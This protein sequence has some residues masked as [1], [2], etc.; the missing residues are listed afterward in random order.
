[1]RKVPL[2]IMS[3]LCISSCK[4]LEDRVDFSEQGLKTAAKALTSSINP[5]ERKANDFKKLV[6]EN[7]F[8]E[9]DS[10][11]RQNK[12]Y[13]DKRYSSQSQLIEQEIR[14]LA[15]E[16]L[17]TSL[18]NEAEQKT[19]SLGSLASIDD[20]K[21]W[22]AQTSL[23]ESSDALI[24]RINSFYSISK[25]FS[26]HSALVS[27]KQ[28]IDESKK[29]INNYKPLAIKY[30]FEEAFVSDSPNTDYFR[31]GFSADNYSAS[32]AYQAFAEQRLK[33]IPTST[34]FKNKALAQGVFFSS[35]TKQNIN[36]HYVML[37]KN[38]IKK[39]GKVSF[40]EVLSLLKTS[41]VP[42]GSSKFAMNEIFRIGYLN[43]DDK[44]LSANTAYEVSV[45]QDTDLPISDLFLENSRIDSI[46]FLIATKVTLRNSA[47]NT[48]S[49]ADVQSRYKSGE[50]QEPNPQYASAFS[51]HQLALA[52]LNRAQMAS[53]NNTKCQ[54][55]NQCLLLGLANGLAEAGASKDLQDTAARLA[56]TPQ[57]ISTPVYQNY[58]YRR[59]EIQAS[60]TAKLDFFIVDVKAKKYY[61]ESVPISDQKRF[62]VIE[63][64]ND[65]DPER[66]NILRGASSM[67]DLQNWETESVKVDMSTLINLNLPGRK[68]AQVFNSLSDLM[69]AERQYNEPQVAKATEA[70]S[71]PK[72]TS[73]LQ[74]QATVTNPDKNGI[75][76]IFIKTNTNTKSLLVNG[77]ELG[78]KKD[79]IYSV[80]RLAKIG[81]N[82]QFE[83]IASD[84]LGNV[85]SKVL[86][87]VRS[88]ATETIAGDTLSLEKIKRGKPSDAI[89]IVIGIQDYER[90]PKADF[91]NEDARMFYEYAVKALGI[92]PENIRLLVDKEASQADILKTFKTWLP[93]K[94]RDKKSD[95]IVFYSGHGL[96]TEDGKSIYFMPYGVDRDVLE[97]SAIE[98]RKLVSLIEAAKPKSVTLFIDSCYS[99]ATRSGE[100]LIASARPLALK[101]NT[102]GFPKHFVVLTASKSDQISSSSN[103]LNHGIFSFYLMKALEGNAD[104]NKDGKLTT[105][106]LHDYLSSK[107]SSFSASQNR[108]QDPQIF[109]DS[110]RVLVAN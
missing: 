76:S 9:A 64:V 61:K 85:D 79:G 59:S 17:K 56:A 36:Q 103:E 18:N 47:K 62:V 73:S 57:L 106:E 7:R 42:F 16:L 41:E 43:L 93:S 97:D 88:A 5:F 34:E 52:N 82:N 80:K 33:D 77:T 67:D 72:S 102:E 92:K 101:S 53:T 12:E 63:N 35:A 87:V 89:A 11:L 51:N 69:P 37:L 19:R 110:G 4:T 99:G 83:I 49:K 104:S 22:R 44:N 20:P 60:K 3:V 105:G 38:E 26:Q 31:I 30:T 10:F 1:M 68:V 40:D 23:L 91:A 50:R 100:T 108:K 14:P 48:I 39:D 98:Q 28:K 27:L 84:F 29:Q 54:N 58:R 13:F 109:G 94:L 21:N 107:V 81:Q 75:V 70:V 15:D 95:L 74:L 65:N 8:E 90:I 24:A 46:D 96:P 2:L 55:T 32:E 71:M 78:A 25:T 66:G 6:T 45:R 86:E